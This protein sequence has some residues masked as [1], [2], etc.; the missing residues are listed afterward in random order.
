MKDSI[1]RRDLKYIRNTLFNLP[2][3]KIFI[4]FIHL[5]G[6]MCMWHIYVQRSEDSLWKSVLSTVHILGSKLGHQAWWQ[7]PLLGEPS[8]QPINIFTTSYRRS[9][10]DK[11]ETVCHLM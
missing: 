1:P 7:V 10:K 11:L 3:I 4:T 9:N 5:N 8:Y 2:Q 6:G